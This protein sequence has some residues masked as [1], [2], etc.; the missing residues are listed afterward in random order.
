[1]SNDSVTSLLRTQL[2]PLCHLLDD[3]AVT[4]IMVN[5]G[6]A[7]FAVKAGI[8][9]PV[10]CTLPEQSIKIAIIAV[11]KHAKNDAVQNTESALVQAQFGNLRFAGALPP[12]SQ[13]GSCMTIRKHNEVRFTMPQLIGK[14]MLTQQQAGL[15]ERLFVHEKKNLIIVGST[16]CGKTTLLNA[17]L[18]L[19]PKSERVVTIQDTPE[20]RVLVPDWVD[21]CT[22]SHCNIDMR[23]LVA[24]AKRKR[25][26]RLVVGE[27][28]GN[29]DA[30]DLI[31]AFLAGHPGIST[32]H[33]GSARGA[34][35]ALEMMYQASL[36]PNASIPV[37]VTR[38]YIGSA[39]GAVA[40]LDRLDQMTADG[41][42]KI[43][44]L[45]EIIR[46]NGVVDGKYEFEQLVKNG[47]STA[48][49]ENTPAH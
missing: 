22:S 35:H 3:P 21:L 42:Q 40:F 23:K 30:Y 41:L 44:F 19:I 38:E 5:P 1:M 11:A 34:L 25:P 24:F 39:I 6:G 49:S 45:S 15:L 20:I 29:G 33:A 43:K 4:E 48:L 47:V 26:D 12:V 28:R 10:D 32:L 7:V 36:P 46:V 9:S 13:G 8:K 27:V 18:E 2:A 17:L 14:G 31:A 37:A 16:D